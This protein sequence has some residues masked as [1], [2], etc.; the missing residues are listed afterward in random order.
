MYSAKFIFAR[1]VWDDE[2]YQLDKQIA[3]AARS[4][5]GYLG[6]EA[7]ENSGTG[8]FCNVYYWESLESLRQLMQHPAHL[9]AKAK[10]AKWLAGYQVV[11]SQILRV[12]GDSNLSGK[13]P[14][15]NTE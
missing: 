7:W 9:E 3:D 14:L 2:F 11:V 10:Q 15:T 13:L 8:L 5:P 6:E 12:Y 1:G 4:T